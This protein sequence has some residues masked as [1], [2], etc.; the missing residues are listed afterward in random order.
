M[1]IKRFTIFIII[2]LVL[3]SCTN[4]VKSKEHLGEI[5]SIALDSLM[6]TDTA[7]NSEMEFVAI[8]MSNFNNLNEQDKAEILSYFTEKYKVDAMDVTFEELKEKGLYNQE[9]MS[10]DGVLLTIEKVDFKL[11]NNVF[12][13]GSKYRSGIGAIGVETTVHYK[14]GK[15]KIK[16][17]KQTWVS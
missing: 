14:G 2:S 15:W 5:Y 11:N 13:E 10:L 7:L 12:F 4:G 1:N 9:T 17:A 3:V 8:D 6:E 16:K